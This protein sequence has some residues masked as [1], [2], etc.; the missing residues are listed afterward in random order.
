LGKQTDIK[1]IYVVLLL[2]VTCFFVYRDAGTTVDNH[3]RQKLNT[4]LREIDGYKISADIA[5]EA[6]VTSMLK[7]DDYVYTNYSK[8]GGKDLTLYIGHYYT[9][10]KLTAAHSPLV[11]YPSQGWSINEPV[12]Y[13]LT[14]GEDTLYYG[15]VVAQLGDKQELIFYW[16][17]AGNKS[18]ID[19]SK[20]K[21]ATAINKL[22]NNNEQHGFVRISVPISGTDQEQARTAGLTFIKAFWPHYLDYIKSNIP[23][24]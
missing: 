24:Q 9:L 1:L 14:I 3:A 17:Q 23:E 5:L 16:Y 12:K 4:F 6:D 10:T 13:Q 11:C 22:Q 8:A 7:L 19:R 18:M 20:L 15:E 2:L 21:L